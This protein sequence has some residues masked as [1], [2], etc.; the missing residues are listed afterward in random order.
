MDSLM[1]TLLYILMD[2]SIFL[3]ILKFI[4]VMTHNYLKCGIFFFNIQ[5]MFHLKV[6]STTDV[7]LH[8]FCCLL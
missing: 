3:K 6:Q 7:E 8:S 4:V 1:K 2:E 5:G